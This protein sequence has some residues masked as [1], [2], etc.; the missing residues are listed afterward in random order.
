MKRMN[1]HRLFRILMKDPD[2][3]SEYEDLGPEFEL[4]EK[5]LS[6]EDSEELDLLKDKT[7]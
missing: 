1:S 4:L 6:E 2:F 5:I 7:T 3:K